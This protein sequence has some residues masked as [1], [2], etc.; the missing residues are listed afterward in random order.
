MRKVTSPC[1]PSTT[2]SLRRDLLR[3]GIDLGTPSGKWLLR[4]LGQ[5]EAATS[6]TPPGKPQKQRRPPPPAERPSPT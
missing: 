3:Q 6:P 1:R 4:L 5:G 2:D